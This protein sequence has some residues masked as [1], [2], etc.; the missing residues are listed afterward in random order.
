[1]ELRA[2]QCRDRQCQRPDRPRCPW[3]M[4]RRTSSS[5]RSGCRPDVGPVAPPVTGRVRNHDVILGVRDDGPVY[6]AVR[7][8]ALARVG[9]V[10]RPRASLNDPTPG[11]VLVASRAITSPSPG[12]R[13]PCR[14]V[15]PRAIHRPALQQEGLHTH[16]SARLPEE[17]VRAAP[18][19]RSM[20]IPELQ[21]PGGGGQDA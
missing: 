2:V 11:R 6:A 20:P 9:S 14:G 10:A 16:G 18:L 21:A 12:E 7:P 13:R 15:L 17:R 8:S 4:F 1:M 19:K 5:R 3:P